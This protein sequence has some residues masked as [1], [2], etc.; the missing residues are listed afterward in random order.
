MVFTLRGL[1]H[2]VCSPGDQLYG[3]IK[4]DG[5]Y[6]AAPVDDDRCKGFGDN[7]SDDYLAC[8]VALPLRE[9]RLGTP[10]RWGFSLMAYRS[11]LLASRSI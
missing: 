8:E 5:L 9:L 7:L 10:L 11:G 1:T 3:E 2:A 4:K 6:R